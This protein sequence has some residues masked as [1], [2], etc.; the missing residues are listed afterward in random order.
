MPWTAIFPGP[1]SRM[2]AGPLLPLA[3]RSQHCVH[4]FSLCSVMA[5]VAFGEPEQLRLVYISSTVAGA[6]AAGAGSTVAEAAAG[7][8]SAAIASAIMAAES[9]LRG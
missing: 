5:M 3:Q 6:A 2:L 9:A 8:G 7:A 4:R 1:R